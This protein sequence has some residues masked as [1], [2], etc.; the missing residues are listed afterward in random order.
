MEARKFSG[1][2]VLV[3]KGDEPAGA[4]SAGVQFSPM[5]AGQGDAL[6]AGRAGHLVHLALEVGVGHGAPE[7]HCNAMES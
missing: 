5:V 2:A 7:F 4:A 3:D 6:G 1:C